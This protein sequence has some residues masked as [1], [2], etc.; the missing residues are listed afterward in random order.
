[1]E[2][3]ILTGAKEKH[4]VKS[5]DQKQVSTFY[6]YIF[7]FKVNKTVEVAGNASEEAEEEPTTELLE[8]IKDQVEVYIYIVLFFCKKKDYNSL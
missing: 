3:R 7:L 5:N 2:N 6:T 1:M 8:K 4:H